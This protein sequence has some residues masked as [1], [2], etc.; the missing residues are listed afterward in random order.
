M[1]LKLWKVERCDVIE[2]DK[3]QSPRYGELSLSHGF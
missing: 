1:R 2:M 3:T